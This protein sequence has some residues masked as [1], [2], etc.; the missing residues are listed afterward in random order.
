MKNKNIIE[1]IIIKHIIAFFLSIPHY[2][3]LLK[4][5]LKVF[6]VHF[7]IQCSL[8][9]ELNHIKPFTTQ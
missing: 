4:A 2:I 8:L 1:Y 9:V 5:K 6:S 3:S 7:S